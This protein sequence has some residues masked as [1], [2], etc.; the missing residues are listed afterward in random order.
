MPPPEFPEAAVV[1]FGTTPAAS[2]ITECL[3]E[4][5][6]ATRRSWF[7]R[8]IGRSPLTSASRPWFVGALGELDI[9]RRLESLDS[10]WTVLHSVP[11]G[12]RGSD[13]DHVVVSAAGVFT[14]NTKLHEGARIWVGARRL[15]VNGQKTDHLRNSRYEGERVARLLSELMGFTVPVHSVLVLVAARSVTVKQ[16]PAEVAVLRDVE[17]VRWLRKRPPSLDTDRTAAIVSAVTSGPTW[18]SST[19]SS[20]VDKSGFNELRRSVNEARRIRGLWSAGFV[21]TV[22][23][24]SAS[25]VLSVF[26]F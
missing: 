3:R 8:V 23:G 12:D 9:A 19:D 11:I 17:M 16:R 24:V 26:S 6:T 15:L 1:G 25:L 18:G 13:I 22:L 4:Q 21:L 10:S 5:Q 2:V 14:I 20:I 7:D